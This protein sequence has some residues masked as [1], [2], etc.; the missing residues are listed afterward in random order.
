[1]LRPAV[2]RLCTLVLLLP[3]LA[4]GDDVT[5]DPSST[6]AGTS[7]SGGTVQ[8]TTTAAPTDPTE[9]PTTEPP[10]TDTT[11]PVDPSTTTTEP[12]PTSATETTGPDS[13][14]TTS[15]DTTESTGNDTECTPGEIG[16]VCDAD[17]EC[18]PEA[19]CWLG[20][21]EKNGGGLCPYEFDGVCDEG[22][23]ICPFGSDPHD[24]CAT[25]E[26]GVCEEQSMGG[27][28]PDGTDLFDCGG[29]PYTNDGFCDEPDACPSGSDEADC[30]AGIENGVCEELGQG[31]DCPVGSDAWD[32]GSCPYANDGFCDEPDYCPSG[33]D[34][35]DCCAGIENGVCEELGQGG[36]CPDGSDF[37][38][39]GECPYDL[40][41]ACDEPFLCPPDS[42]G[43]CCAT[44][45]NG[46]CE[47]LGQ[48]GMCPDGTDDYDCGFCPYTN[49]GA[50]DEPNFC[51]PD[52]DGEDCCATPKN[53]VCEEL[54]Q[55]GMCPDG[56]DNYDCGVCPWEND[57]E[58][59]VPQL[60]PPGTDEADC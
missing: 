3:P 31:G 30:C 39:C 36:D 27:A 48:G 59:D 20:L 53:G 11:A 50:C 8:D 22:N 44:V 23:G 24:C 35:A 37:W 28:C 43:D 17:A 29:C 32:C 14:S 42:D 6:T 41:G 2:V 15:T 60:C 10:T 21:C 1:M 46:V 25:P 52:S 57:A 5:I 45:K 56:S 47:E 34:E 18:V 12:D 19:T 26:N 40:D 9:T 38:D 54:G 7:T 33:S 51:P 4:C 13:D 16:C 49:D 58:C 55:G